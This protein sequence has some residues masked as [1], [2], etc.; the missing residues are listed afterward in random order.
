MDFTRRPTKDTVF[1]EPARSVYGL[2]AY[3]KGGY[4]LTA[5]AAEEY[6][7]STTL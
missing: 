6:P 7:E 3:F 4:D 5:T 2:A 1:V